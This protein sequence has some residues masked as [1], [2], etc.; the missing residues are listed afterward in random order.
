[1]ASRV[2]PALYSHGGVSKS[3]AAKPNSPRPRESSRRPATHH[4]QKFEYIAT[5]DEL[6]AFVHRLAPS[7]PLALDT[8]FVGENT[9]TP[10][11][12]LIQIADSEGRIGLIDIQTVRDF[13]PLK[14]IVRDP[15]RTKLFH[16]AKQ[17]IFLLHRL[18][19]TPPAPSFD[20]QVAA[21][22]VGL[23]AQL[24]YVNLVRLLL[25]VHIKGAET[26]SDWSKRPL[27]DAQQ[28]YA[29]QDVEFLHRLHE[30]LQ[31]RVEA[32]GR[33][34]WLRE[35]LER[36]VASTLEDDPTPDDER[37]RA[38]RD[39]MK[40]DGI[41][42]AILREL[43][44]WR[45]SEARKRNVSRRLVLPDETLIA[46]ARRGPDSRGDLGDL[47]RIPQGQ[48]YR[49]LDDVL[50]VIRRAKKIP[51]DQWPQKRAPKRPDIPEGL[52]EL[53]QAIV[54]ST[55]DQE[56]I[57]ASLLTTREE[58]TT[59]AIRRHE[60]HALDIPVL[61][62]WRRTMIGEKL[63]ELLDGR[64]HLRIEERNRVIIDRK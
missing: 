50:Q 58:L 7:G 12:E 20:T 19:G 55:A 36:R 49:C 37:Y 43:A 18:L 8:E 41:Q 1:M 9:Y 60:P 31:Q 45:E 14:R 59:L 42:L 3:L 27:T 2:D 51:K 25:G 33:T 47:R 64:M 40:L 56:S 57:A 34:D 32:L 35:E 39:W 21:A 15:K 38:V 4:T 22:M 30:T 24:S 48:L 61:Q 6:R 23:G 52:V 11:L 26:V 16:S 29:A 5:D 44:V 54:R 17:D 62:G 63:L 13:T 10:V 28:V 53:F 46:L